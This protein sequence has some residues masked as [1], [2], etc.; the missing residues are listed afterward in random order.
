MDN[1]DGKTKCLCLTMTSLVLAVTVIVGVSFGGVEPTEYGILY[2]QVTKQINTD[3]ILD[4]GLQYIGVFN[5]LIAFPRNN[6]QV[7]FSDQSEA[8]APPLSTRTKEGLE[9]KLHFAFLYKLQKENIPELYR[10]VGTEYEQLYIR[11]ASDLVLQNAGNYH[12]T[13]Y[14]QERSAIGN[15][16]EKALN[17]KL[18]DAYA[19]CTGF[20]LLRIDLPDS[21]EEAIVETQ[22]VNQ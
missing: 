4:G 5:K 10:L 13:Q 22:L 3:N 8:Q 21:Y 7:E 19:N 9:L 2:N 12:A 18:Q 11:I 17:E 6:K 16:L 15:A 14:W 1:F 20:M